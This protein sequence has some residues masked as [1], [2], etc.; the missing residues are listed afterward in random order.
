[1]NRTNKNNNKGFTLVE[2]IITLTVAAI[3]VM[4]EAPGLG[5]WLADNRLSAQST[6]LIAAIRT[7]RSEAVKRMQTI[8][9]CASS[10]V[11]TANPSCNTTNWEAG[12]IIFNDA[13]A[14]AAF[15]AGEQLLA[16]GNALTGGTTLRSRNPS[17]GLVRFSSTGTNI[18]ATPNPTS[19]MLCDSRGVNKAKQIQLLASGDVHL[20]TVPNEETCP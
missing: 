12:W 20:S 8:T 11:T 1:M 15:D 9:I 16:M 14:N 13:N 18:A 19:W 6:Q 17:N 4:M 2:L 5:T 10:N 7:A 3:L